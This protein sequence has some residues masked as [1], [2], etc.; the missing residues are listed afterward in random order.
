MRRRQP[1]HAITSMLGNMLRLIGRPRPRQSKR[2]MSQIVSYRQGA[3]SSLADIQSPVILMD[4]LKRSVGT[5]RSGMRDANWISKYDEYLRERCAHVTTIVPF[6]GKWGDD[7]QLLLGD[8]KHRF[9][10]IILSEHENGAAAHDAL[11]RSELFVGLRDVDDGS[12]TLAGTH[13]AA[14]AALPRFNGSVAATEPLA[15]RAPSE[16]PFINEPTAYRNAW[17]ALHTDA[18]DDMLAFNLIRAP[19]SAAYRDYSAHFAPLPARHGMRFVQVAQLHGLDSVLVCDAELTPS[20][21]EQHA[22]FDLM[23]L[24]HFPSSARFA[25]AW[26]DPQIVDAAYSIRQQMLGNGF[27]HVWLRYQLPEGETAER[28]VKRSAADGEE[29]RAASQTTDEEGGRQQ[30]HDEQQPSL[31]ISLLAGLAIILG[32]LGVNGA[33]Y[34]YRK[35][36]IQNAHW[37]VAPDGSNGKARANGEN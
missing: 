8:P 26:S 9:D 30:A 17:T 3:L 6:V 18:S 7:V 12:F 15:G 23:A 20:Q 29:A 11:T 13:S 35:Q 33:Y 24:V 28:L 2:S 36:T 16:C 10:T 37:R 4:C 32:A 21:M 31:N 5:T 34:L 1:A 14:F 19:D 25:D 22:A 27:R